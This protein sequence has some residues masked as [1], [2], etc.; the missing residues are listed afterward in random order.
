MPM[1]RPWLI[2]L[3]SNNPLFP[4]RL[5]FFGRRPF[6]IFCKGSGDNSFKVLPGPDLRQH[7]HHIALDLAG[8]LPETLPQRLD[9]TG[10]QHG[11]RFRQVLHTVA[12]TI[13]FPPE[14]GNAST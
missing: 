14:R 13:P 8:Q 2:R 12:F 4:G 11:R 3:P 1:Q 10:G 7:L 6:N 9:Q 5:K